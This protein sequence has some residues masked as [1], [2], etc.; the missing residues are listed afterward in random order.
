MKKFIALGIL[1][2]ISMTNIFADSITQTAA[3]IRLYKTRIIDMSELDKSYD[4]AI[5]LLKLRQAPTDSVTKSIMLESLISAELIKQEAE[6]EKIN[7][8]ESEISTLLN[9]QKAEFEKQ[10]NKKY[11]LKEYEDLL[12]KEANTTKDEVRKSIKETL[13]TQRYLFS[14]IEPA[15]KLKNFEPTEDEIKQAYRETQANN[16]RP[17]MVRLSHILIRANEN[18]LLDA[19]NKAKA[20][21]VA[22]DL[23][24]HKI[25]WEKAVL[26]YSEDENSK[27]QNGDLNF[28]RIDDKSIKELLGEDFFNVAFDLG[29]GETSD[30]VKT[31]SGY[32]ILKQ[33]AHYDA[34][35][36]KLD[37]K[38]SPIEETTLHDLLKS[39]LTQI[40]KQSAQEE[41]IK[42]EIEELKKRASITILYKEE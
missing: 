41:E 30:V 21:K 40:K 37:S 5:Q 1:I 7:V 11:T 29:V 15:L 8:S 3:I 10:T 13:L 28:L 35:L 9:Q 12:S 19:Q 24:E 39:Q 38:I 16:V 27:N 6:H 31:I 34:E 2:L 14:K 23:K 32:H 22:K 18:A 33:V 17:E 4:N 20:E 26:D 42:K 36:L 25:T